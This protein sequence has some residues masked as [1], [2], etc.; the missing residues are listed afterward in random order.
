[1]AVLGVVVGPTETT[2]VDMVYPMVVGS[3][4]GAVALSVLQ[5]WLG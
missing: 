5:E 3:K 2:G 4:A 1:M